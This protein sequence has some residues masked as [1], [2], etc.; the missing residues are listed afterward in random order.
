[1]AKK[2]PL[3]ADL[4]AELPELTDAWID[5]IAAE[6]D[7]GTLAAEAKRS[8]FRDRAVSTIESALSTLDTDEKVPRETLER[9]GAR[10][11]ETLGFVSEVPIEEIVSGLNLL[12]ICVW[13]KLEDKL[14]SRGMGPQQT[15]LVAHNLSNIMNAV[16][17]AVTTEYMALQKRRESEQRKR[18][19]ELLM[20]DPATGA[21]NM[22]HFMVLLDREIERASR[23]D[24]PLALLMVDCDDLKQVNDTYGHI[25]GNRLILKL[26]RLFKKGL[27]KYDVL[28]R[29]G[30]DEFLVLLPET[31]KELAEQIAERLRTA[32]DEQAFTVGLV[33]VRTS[34]SVGV[35]S[36]PDDA[37]DASDLIL[38]ADNA[39]YA[40]KR[41]GKNQVKAFGPDTRVLPG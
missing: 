27:R 8:E 30:G 15:F 5:A 10:V 13:S 21:Y 6:P 7:L 41:A 39:M 1:M 14:T 23:H 25:H 16:S 12:R 36:V 37:S 4:M 22:R 32:V 17:G 26:V 29:Y 35:A 19:R 28:A 9:T 33:P 3:L 18:E 24:R 2:D 38:M 34:V 40:A 31:T 20:R 11:A